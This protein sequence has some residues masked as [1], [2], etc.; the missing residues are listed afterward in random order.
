MVRRWLIPIIFFETYLTV[1]ALLFFFGPWPWIVPNPA[2]IAIYLAAANVVVFLGYVASRPA[3]GRV[4]QETEEER[5]RKGI[6]WLRVSTAASVALTV[7]TS[8]ARTGDFFPNVLASLSNLGAVYSAG[9]RETADGG[10]FVF[11][12]YVRMF[13]YPLLSAQLPLTVAFWRRAGRFVR[14]AAVSSITFYLLIFIGRGQNKGLADIVA[15]LPFFLVLAWGRRPMPS[16]RKLCISVGVVVAAALVLLVFFAGT[17]IQRIGGAHPDGVYYFGRLKLVADQNY[18]LTY[19]MPE[20]AQMTIESL[21]RYLGQGYQAMALTFNYEHQSTLG[22]GH[23][24]FVARNFD[25]LLHTDFFTSASLPALLDAQ[26]GWPMY[27]LWHS[28]YPW[29]ASDV[30]YLGALPCMAAFGFLLG[31]SWGAAFKSGSIVWMGMLPMMLVL[32]FYI[33]G[34]NQI[35]QSGETTVAFFMLAPAVALKLVYP[36]WSLSRFFMPRR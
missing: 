1:V 16:L 24:M 25:R 12:E 6:F 8:L 27:G 15:L 13:A 10:P 34:N 28:I 19:W 11:F 14:A 21:A 29:L 20:P 18:W 26:W 22:A 2:E 35:F 32:F 9:L 5:I 7:P 3:L 30:G 33:P 17:Q 36:K 23:S 31:L 4:A